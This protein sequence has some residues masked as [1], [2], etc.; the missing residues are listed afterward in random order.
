MTHATT[1]IKRIHTHNLWAALSMIIKE[2]ATQFPEGQDDVA[3]WEWARVLTMTVFEAAKR[4]SLPPEVIIEKTRR[5]VKRQ[6]ERQEASEYLSLDVPEFP[7]VTDPVTD[8]K[9]CTKA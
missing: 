3:K 5:I 4:K 7:N 9:S 6:L 2:A 1:P 8:G